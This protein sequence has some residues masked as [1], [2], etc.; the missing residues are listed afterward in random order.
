L[1]DLPEDERI[2]IIGRLAAGGAVTGFIVDDDAKAD[3][4]LAKLRKRFNVRVI[5]RAPGP[6]N[7]TVTVVVGPGES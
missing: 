1:G 5:Q 2:E 7:N 4:Y 6:V 3:R